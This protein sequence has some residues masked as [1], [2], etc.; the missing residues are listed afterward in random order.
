MTAKNFGDIVICEVLLL[1][2]ENDSSVLICQ[3]EVNCST[4]LKLGRERLNLFDSFV[5][6]LFLI[7]CLGFVT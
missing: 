6:L 3:N 7:S 5:I 1:C 4:M 2:G